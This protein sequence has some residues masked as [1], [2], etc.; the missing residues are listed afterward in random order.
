MHPAL[1]LVQSTK[2]KL[3]LYSDP[4]FFFPYVIRSGGIYAVPSTRGRLAAEPL[5]SLLGETSLEGM[6]C[7]SA[8]V[9]LFQRC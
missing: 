8:L 9:R 1:E 7:L 6:C 4:S 3:V 2:N 5:A